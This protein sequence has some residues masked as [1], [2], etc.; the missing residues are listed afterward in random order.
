VV[1]HPLIA[2]MR[3]ERKCA[4]AKRLV[5]FDSQFYE[6]QKTK[7]EGLHFKADSELEILRSILRVGGSKRR[8]ERWGGREK[9]AAG[10]AAKRGEP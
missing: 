3:F 7:K 5:C 8:E 4:T 9:K 6:P 2:D 1:L 10:S